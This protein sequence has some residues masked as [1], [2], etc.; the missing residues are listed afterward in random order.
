MAC[1]NFLGYR[2]EDTELDKYS[3]DAGGV[4]VNDLIDDRK[5]QKADVRTNCITRREDDT[6]MILRNFKRLMV[7]VAKR[8]LISMKSELKDAPLCSSSLWF[9]AVLPNPNFHLTV[10]CYLGR[11]VYKCRVQMYTTGEIYTDIQI[12]CGR[13]SK[14]CFT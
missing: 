6:T 1:I 4:N 3:D 11:E 2:M 14:K 5:R 9:D 8:E 7:E 13:I 10:R 12:R